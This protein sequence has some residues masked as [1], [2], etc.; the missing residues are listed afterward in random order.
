MN[1]FLDEVQ[2]EKDAIFNQLFE[3]CDCAI[4][5][6][7]IYDTI[8]EDWYAEEYAFHDMCLAWSMCQM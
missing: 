2:T 3:D 6:Q 8:Q 7:S 4:D 5:W 1:P